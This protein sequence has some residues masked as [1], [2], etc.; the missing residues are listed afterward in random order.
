LTSSERKVESENRTT[1][2]ALYKATGPEPGL[3]NTGDPCGQK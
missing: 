3:I 1:L 2:E